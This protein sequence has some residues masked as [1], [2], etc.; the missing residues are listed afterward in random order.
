MTLE[1]INLGGDP[2]TLRLR[3]AGDRQRWLRDPAAIGR[4]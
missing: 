4:T 1:T 2:V 3:S